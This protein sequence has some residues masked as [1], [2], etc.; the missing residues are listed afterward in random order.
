MH[1]GDNVDY[2]VV[3]QHPYD[4]GH[5]I[6]PEIFRITAYA[7]GMFGKWAGGYEGSVSTPDKRGIDEYFGYICQFGPISIIRIS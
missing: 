6:I 2:S 4:P 3:G 7:T 1:Y 5:V